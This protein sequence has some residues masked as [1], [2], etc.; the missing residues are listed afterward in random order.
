[1]VNW[2]RG[3][4][5][6]ILT[7]LS[8][9]G[10][11]AYVLALLRGKQRFVSFVLIYAVFSVGLHLLGPWRVS[12]ARDPHPALHVPFFYTA[13]NRNFVT[14]EMHSVVNDLA[15]HMAQR[16]P[17]TQTVVLDGGFPAFDGLPLLPHLSHDDGEKLD[18]GFY[19]QDG[20]GRYL[21]GRM[22]S[23]I[24][25][26]GYAEGHSA[27]PKTWKDLRWDFAWLQPWLPGLQ[28][29]EPRMRAALLWLAEDPRVSKILIEPHVTA[30]L[31][32]S[33][34][35]IRF[36]GCRAAR[37]DDHIHFQL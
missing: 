19:W 15:A 20:A 17:D 4:I 25:F 22:K 35:K 26:W 24:G 7:A 36:Q 32:I 16:F 5:A 3:L 21:P 18:L 1:M 13:L 23:P 12:L 6:L 14:P 29:D 33:H 30:R 9:I 37:H 28:L 31:Q 27:C 34:P 10:G 8:F 11:L 2:I